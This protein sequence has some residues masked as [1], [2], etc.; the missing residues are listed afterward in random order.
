M[1]LG[2]SHRT[3]QP[4]GRVSISAPSPPFGR[5]GSSRARY[6]GIFFVQIQ[7]PSPWQGF[8]SAPIRALI[9]PCTPTLRTSSGGSSLTLKL[10]VRTTRDKPEEA[11]RAVRQARPALG[12]GL[13]SGDVRFRSSMLACYPE[14]IIAVTGSVTIMY[15]F[16]PWDHT[17]LGQGRWI[18]RRT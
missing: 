8:P 4:L 17:A 1:F 11:V 7:A 3:H 15:V 5:L 16:C 6:L 14:R 12:H 9:D 13:A 18:N 2:K 10:R